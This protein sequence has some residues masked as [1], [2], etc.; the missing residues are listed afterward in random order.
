[1]RFTMRFTCSPVTPRN[2]AIANTVGSLCLIFVEKSL[3]LL[4]RSPAG[5]FA[6]RSD[7]SVIHCFS[8]RPVRSAADLSC[9]PRIDSDVAIRQH[10]VSVSVSS[11]NS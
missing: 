1:M 10:D 4:P 2:A 7:P 11:R 8:Y 5:A 6:E 3:L 9:G